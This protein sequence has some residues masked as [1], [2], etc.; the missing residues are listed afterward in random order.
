[1]GLRR[2]VE[3]PDDRLEGAEE[4]AGTALKFFGE[5]RI[6]C[7][8]LLTA[9][10]KHRAVDATTVIHGRVPGAGVAPVQELWRPIRSGAATGSRGNCARCGLAHGHRTMAGHGRRTVL[11]KLEQRGWCGCRRVGWSRQSPS[12]GRAAPGMGPAADHRSPRELS[13]VGIEEVANSVG[14]EELRA[15][16]AHFTIWLPAAAER[17]CNTQCGTEPVAVRGG[18][19]RAA[20]SA[21]RGP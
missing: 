10:V 17:T 9:A 15:V 20:W 7:W 1:V 5:G 19:R 6:F 13:S 21:R 18:V 11:L 3:C 12:F 16:L 4:P 8:L 14:A 2:T